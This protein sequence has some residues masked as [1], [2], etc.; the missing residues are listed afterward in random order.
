MNWRG[1]HHYQQRFILKACGL[2]GG[3]PVPQ[4]PTEVEDADIAMRRR[5]L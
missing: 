1:R 2:Y 5:R 3:V 4:G